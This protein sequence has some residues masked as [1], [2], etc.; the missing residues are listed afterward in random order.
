M[1]SATNWKSR[2]DTTHAETLHIYVSRGK[3]MMPRRRIREERDKEEQNGIGTGIPLVR[4]SGG[5]RW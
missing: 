5:E 4:W 3:E 2:E 1:V